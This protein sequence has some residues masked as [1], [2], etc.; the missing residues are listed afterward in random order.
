MKGWYQRGEGVGGGIIAIM[1]SL[2]I[3]DHRAERQTEGRGKRNETSQNLNAKE[4]GKCDG[5]GNL[6][7][8]GGGGGGCRKYSRSTHIT[9]KSDNIRIH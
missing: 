6:Q 1:C 5:G 8:G 2:T 7:A 4:R 9:Y 3:F